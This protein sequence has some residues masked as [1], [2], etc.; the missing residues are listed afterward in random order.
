[1]QLGCFQQITA[2]LHQQ[3][4]RVDDMGRVLAIDLLEAQAGQGFG[5]ARKRCWA[6]LRRSCGLA[7]EKE[8][9]FDQ[10]GFA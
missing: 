10:F 9:S 8:K 7:S 2:I 5:S 3:I 6:Q 1:L 4:Q